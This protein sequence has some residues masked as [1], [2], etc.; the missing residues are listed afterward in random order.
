MSTNPS[1]P[2]PLSLPA[3]L[4]EA[5]LID[6]IEGGAA[7]LTPE[8]ERVMIEALR[9]E[10]RLGLLIK[11]MRAERTAVAEWGA[12][13]AAAPG[14]LIEGIEAKLDR[15]ALSELVAES[16]EAPA[17]I[18]IS[19][20][21][22]MRRGLAAIIAESVWSRR[23]ATAASVA[24]VG[25]LG[26]FAVRELAKKWPA[27]PTVTPV[28]TNTTK[29]GDANTDSSPASTAIAEATTNSA[30]EAMDS[31]PT[32]PALAKADPV[33]GPASVEPVALTA[34]EAVRLAEQGR[35][36]I[37]VRSDA[38]EGTL[39]HL[40]E[41]SRTADR[42]DRWRAYEPSALPQEFA[43]LA[44]PLSD[45]GLAPASPL[46]PSRPKMS[47]PTYASEG[48]ALSPRK[49]EKT[50]EPT[51][52][53]P[54]RHVVVR[55]LRVVQMD[56]EAQS[57]DDLLR[58]INVSKAHT[59]RFRVLPEGAALDVRP[60]LDPE[61]VLWWSRGGEGAWLK[62]ISVPIVVETVE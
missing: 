20:V 47:L 15:N 34:T 6:L 53:F 11:Q 8:L 10:P 32:G 41:L 21:Q 9:Q 31:S 48:Q 16:E 56:G 46:I 24:I 51:L 25:G 4:T 27:L 49:V 5:D 44:A 35:L 14:N 38:Y 60:S 3:G 12:T 40:Q 28:V 1:N 42:R 37:T 33:V 18:P 7:A 58:D 29:P 52:Q 19:R 13:A 55:T 59:A 30:P 23:L 62:R 61:S 17:P 45:D 22:P 26:Y 54:D 57:L 43:A 36:V 2:P 39:R 50:P